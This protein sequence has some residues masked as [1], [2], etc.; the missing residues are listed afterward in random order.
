[1]LQELQKKADELE[2]LGI[3]A[4]P[5]D[6][7]I[8][9][10]HA[11]PSLLIR[12]GAK[13]RLVTTFNDL[14]PYVR[15]PPTASSD[16][17]SVLRKLSKWKYIIKTDMKSAYFQ[18]PLAKNSMQYVGTVTP[19]KGLRVYTRPAMGLPGS[20]EYLQELLS[21]VLGNEMQIGFVMVNADDMYV[22]GDNIQEL[23]SHW[24]VVL[25]KMKLNNLKLNS[26]KTVICP[27][28]TEILGWIWRQGTLSV[29]S[30][31]ISALLAAKPPKT[32]SAMRSF[33]GAYKAMSRCIPKYASLLSPLEDSLKGL[34]GNQ[35]IDWTDTLQEQFIKTQEALKSPNVITI[36][37]PSDSLIIT[38]DGSPVNK[39]LGATLFSVR[40]GKKL[41]SGFFSMKMKVHQEG[42]YPCEFEALAISAAIEHFGPYI[43]ES[44]N[45]VQILTDSKPCVQ[46]FQKLCKGEFSASAR[47]STFLTQLS[48]YNV[49][50]H[51]IKGE[52]NASSDYSSRNP[53]EC[54]NRSCQ[55]CKFVEETAASEVRTMNVDEV[56]SGKL[57]MP[58][59]NT[60]AWKSAQQESHDLRRAFAHLTHGT[61]PSKKTKNIKHLRTY[62]QKCSIN[63]QG[64]IITRKSDQHNMMERE[65]IVVPCEILRGLVTA[66][67]TSF[68]HPTAHQLTKMFDRYFY[69]IGSNQIIKEVTTQCEL[70]NSLKSVPKEIFEQSSSLSPATVGRKF[71]AD[72]I[73]RQKQHI[74]AIR[75]TLSSYTMSCIL[76]DQTGESLRTALL[77]SS[78]PIRLS[79]CEIRLDNAPGFI[80]IKGD[81]ILKE[82][83]ITLDFG[84]IKNINK[85]PVAERCNQELE[86]EL[87]KIDPSGSPVTQLVLSNA[88][89]VLNSRIRHQGLSAKEIVFGRD[90]YTG[91]K[92][93]V[94]GKEIS[95]KQDKLRK[96]NHKPSAYSKSKSKQQAI[97]ASVDV[98]DLVFIKTEGSKNTPRERYIIV[99]IQGRNA[100]LQKMNTDKFCSKRY[101]V[102]LSKL[103][104][105]IEKKGEC[106]IPHQAYHSDSDST[107]EEDIQDQEPSSNEEEEEA[108]ESEDEEEMEAENELDVGQ[109]LRPVRERR[110]PAWMRDPQWVRD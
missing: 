53:N 83:G 30:H 78:A 65:L 7:G 59:T 103:Y 69:G 110:E 105:I 52:N 56:M 37:T 57:R 1:M 73:Q 72:V 44:K 35:V 38:T 54:L 79:P 88:T 58:F 66:I 16:C 15:I 4:K 74:L 49:S 13:R 62:L 84:K 24:T 47:V 32:C 18:I 67:H 42:W 86:K 77:I 106:F 5:E 76:P 12:E 102:P 46:A 22:G 85:N 11:S 21:R 39:G 98:G 71:A 97:D 40:N 26:V 14:S 31:K 19:Y 93:L 48:A 55:I 43:R 87:L 104:P 107:S 45:K 63:N 27:I 9:V 100:F 89:D 82:K 10:Q 96:A 81:H 50:V 70:C 91:N 34:Q 68:N 6:L 64:L 92:L 8:T 95:D 29:S 36:P 20:G 109:V 75:D 3:L 101:E 25:E 33:I 99:S 23:I 80:K 41:V 60:S 2:E 28:E 17:N 108:S 61:R 90:Q 51:H 94:D